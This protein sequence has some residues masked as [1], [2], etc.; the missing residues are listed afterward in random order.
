MSR[1]D[2]R[3][4]SWK[5]VAQSSHGGVKQGNADILPPAFIIASLVYNKQSPKK[6]PNPNLLE[7]LE[8]RVSECPNHWAGSHLFFVWLEEPW[9][10]LCRTKKPRR[11]HSLLI[12]KVS[13]QEVS[14]GWNH[15]GWGGNCSKAFCKTDV[16]R[17]R[18]GGGWV[19]L[20]PLYQ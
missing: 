8:Y 10:L 5:C 3:C 13:W 15:L 7:G 1:R 18:T 17:H 9:I 2:E 20:F 6:K 14:M 12:W 19:I 11:T 16:L 4:R